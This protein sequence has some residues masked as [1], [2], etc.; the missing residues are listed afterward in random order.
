MLDFTYTCRGCDNRFSLLVGDPKAELCPGCTRALCAEVAAEISAELLEDLGR[1]NGERALPAAPAA[2]PED[3]YDELVGALL[4]V[5]DLISARAP[6]DAHC[7][8]EDGPLYRRVFE[9]LR[10]AAA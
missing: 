1:Q 7:R 6:A 2:S 3:L 10:K 8:P 5:Q 9:A 4:D